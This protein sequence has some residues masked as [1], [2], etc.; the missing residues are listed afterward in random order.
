MIMKKQKKLSQ[1]KLNIHFLLKFLIRFILGCISK[2][3][4]Y[5]SYLIYLINK[6]KLIFALS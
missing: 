3:T 6:Q 2:S 4:K 1:I 5:R